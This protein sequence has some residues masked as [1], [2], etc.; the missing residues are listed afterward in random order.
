MG[1]S[2]SGGV[3][4][5]AIGEGGESAIGKKRRDQPE[6]SQRG[7]GGDRRIPNRTRKKEV[8]KG[9]TKTPA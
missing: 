8:G 3:A 2:L 6:R 9:L 4:Y 5:R 7:K 1:A